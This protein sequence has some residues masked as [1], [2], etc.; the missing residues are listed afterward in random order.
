MRQEIAQ[1][2]IFN[3]VME[4]VVTEQVKLPIPVYEVIEYVKNKEEIWEKVIEEPWQQNVRYKQPA[5]LLDLFS[6]E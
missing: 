3:E 1:E 5:S 6:I 2:E 4:Q